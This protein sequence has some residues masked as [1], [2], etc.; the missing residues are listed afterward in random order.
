ME[1]TYI[2]DLFWSRDENAIQLV[3]KKYNSTCYSIAWKILMNREDSEECVNDTWFAAW[4]ARGLA[5]SRR[6]AR[7]FRGAPPLLSRFSWQYG[8]CLQSVILWASPA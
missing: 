6:E 3:D 2:I 1:D 8:V 7:P 5:P 4:R